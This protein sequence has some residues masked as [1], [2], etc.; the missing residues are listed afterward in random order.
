MR[1]DV[2][3]SPSA[4]HVLSAALSVV[5]H[6]VFVAAGT[7]WL[8]GWSKS[9][10]GTNDR[11]VAIKLVGETTS[12]T[13]PDLLQDDIPSSSSDASS[14]KINP[15]ITADGLP[16]ELPRDA[17]VAQSDVATSSQI[18]SA[19]EL[20]SALGIAG[21]VGIGRPSFDNSEDIAAV[22]QAEADRR[23]DQLQRGAAAQ[24]EVFG[25]PPAQGHSFVFVID[26]SRSMGETGLNAI[27]AAKHELLRSLKN[28]EARHEFQIVTYNR[29]IHYL[30]RRKLLPATEENKANAAK[31]LD[32]LIAQGPTR[33]LPAMLSALA[34]RP[35]V[36]YLLTDGDDP[37]IEEKARAQIHKAAE[38]TVI[39]CVQFG[40]GKPVN[41]LSQ[42]CLMTLARENKGQY[43]F[44]DMSRLP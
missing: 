31:F 24:I 2:S 32:K 44:I 27:T 10:I 17:T 23:G 1:F 30:S 36:V 42:E 35:D 16:N 37:Y 20:P 11:R 34:K 22:M 25:L 14:S 19:S 41:E 6:C 18:G 5:L 21:N 9:E 28:L 12:S 40:W 26:C 4:R 39:H 43:A 33:H 7:S 15:A 8:A 13:H 3:T 29:E 38:G